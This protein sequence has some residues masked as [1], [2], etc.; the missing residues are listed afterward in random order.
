MSTQVTYVTLLVTPRKHETQ[1]YNG[2]LL[3]RSLLHSWQLWQR[4]TESRDQNRVLTPYE[5]PDVICFNPKDKIGLE[6]DTE[7]IPVFLNVE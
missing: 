6:C 3:P 1:N 4:K 7:G 2:V 5:F